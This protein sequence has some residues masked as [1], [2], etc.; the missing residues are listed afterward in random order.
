MSNIWMKNNIDNIVSWYIRLWLQILVN[1]TLNIITQF[2]C[3]F[4][5]GVILPSTRHAQCQ[6]TFRNK[7]RK[8]SNHNI[9]EIHKSTTNINIQFDQFNSTRKALKHIHSSDVSC[10]MEKLNTQSQVLKPVGDSLISGLM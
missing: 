4:G 1:G 5:L 7:R 8:S 3:K 6:V 9:C 10:I 2:E